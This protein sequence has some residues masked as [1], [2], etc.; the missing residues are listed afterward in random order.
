MKIWQSRWID[1]QLDNRWIFDNSNF[2]LLNP[3]VIVK[4]VNSFLFQQFPNT[5]IRM[6]LLQITVLTQYFISYLFGHSIMEP[7]TLLVNSTTFIPLLF[8]FFQFLLSLWSHC[9][10]TSTWCFGYVTLFFLF[11]FLLFSE[12]PLDFVFLF[13]KFFLKFL[14]FFYIILYFFYSLF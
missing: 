13:F 11:F 7:C 12:I 5:G 10:H 9:L 14:L 1:I 2:R 4:T 6:D 3:I 8:F